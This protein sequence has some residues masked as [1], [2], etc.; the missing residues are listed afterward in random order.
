MST[1]RQRFA[2]LTAK[3]LARVTLIAALVALL[4]VVVR[5]D[6]VLP[7]VADLLGLV[8]IRPDPSLLFVAALLVLSGALRRR[9]LRSGKSCRTS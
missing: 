2:E 7:V 5:G 4:G 8:I 9:L 6:W 1:G 3:W